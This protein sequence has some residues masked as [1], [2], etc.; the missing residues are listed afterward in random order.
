[1]F[2]DL[3]STL[4]IALPA[5][6]ANMIPVIGAKVNIFPSLNRPLDHGIVWRKKRLLGDNK[7]VRG[8]VLGVGAAIIVSV[9]QHN[10]SFLPQ[11]HFLH[12]STAVSFGALAGCGALLGDA[13]ASMYKRQRDIPSGKPCIPLDQIDYMIGFL[14]FTSLLV[15]WDW[16]EVASLV[17]FALIANPL[18]NIT[19]YHL[20]IKKTY[21]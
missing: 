11:T 14:L 17:I 12:L 19:A 9:I 5:F 2:Y 7:T 8:L 6:V 10:L 13:I 4:Y 21:W 20:T 1:M 18:V 3:L 15:H 16:R